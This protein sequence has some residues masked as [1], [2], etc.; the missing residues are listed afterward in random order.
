MERTLWEG[1][2]M[3]KTVW[4]WF[5]NFEK[6]EKWINEMAAQGL[7]LIHYSFTKYVFAEGEPGK[8][9]YRIELL[10]NIPSHP[11]SMAYIRFLEDAGIEHVAT[12]FR[13]VY[14]R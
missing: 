9:I 5:M 6:E 11:E 3:N 4:K 14:F 12:H 7:H 10:E 1:I 13:W 2:R 8:Y